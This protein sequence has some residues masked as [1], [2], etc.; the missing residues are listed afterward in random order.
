MLDM[1]IDPEVRSRLEQEK[2]IWLTTIAPSGTPVPN[3][4]WFLLDGDDV[5]IYTDPASRKVANIE[6]Q[7]L[8]SVHSNSDHDGGDFYVLTGT[9]TLHPGRQPSRFPGYLDKYR[10]DIVGPL[11]TTVEAIDEQYDTEIRVSV[12]RV[13]GM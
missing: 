1:T 8:V 6:Q 12:D 10:D 13:R 3:P 4:V 11:D 2:V 7:S 9:A 5:V